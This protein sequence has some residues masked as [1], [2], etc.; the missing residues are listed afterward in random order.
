M[1]VTQRLLTRWGLPLGMLLA[2]AGCGARAGG[3]RTVTPGNGRVPD[4]PGPDGQQ[5]GNNIG[6]LKHRLD[7]LTVEQAE[8]ASTSDASFDTCEDLCSLASS[9]CSVKEK[10]C[11]IADQH[12][13]EDEYQQLCRKAELQCSE[14]E[15]SCVACVAARQSHGGST[16]VSK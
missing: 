15:D 7:A 11:S 3:G 13:G 16:A 10:M 4:G 2:V 5:E 12:P 6:D 1:S 9:I 14:A 8:K